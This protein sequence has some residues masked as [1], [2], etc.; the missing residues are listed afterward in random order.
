M[1]D[2]IKARLVAVLL[3]LIGCPFFLWFAYEYFQTGQ[4][5]AAYHAEYAKQAVR[6]EAVVTGF[7][8]HYWTAKGGRTVESV[9]ILAR[10][11][12]QGQLLDTELSGMAPPPPASREALVGRRFEIFH[13]PGWPHSARWAPTLDTMDDGSDSRYTAYLFIAVAVGWAF[14]GRALWRA[15]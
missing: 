8:S 13:V 9:A 4:S 7:K 12:H 15:A 14:F 1:T 3:V 6:A 5:Q 10:F 2:Q 11:E